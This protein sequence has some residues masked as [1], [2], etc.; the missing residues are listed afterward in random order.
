MPWNPHAQMP[1]RTVLDLSPFIRP[2]QAYVA[3]MQTRAELYPFLGYAGFD[4]RDR[5]YFGH[6]GPA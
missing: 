6:A 2:Q 3:A 4:E 1:C 5:T